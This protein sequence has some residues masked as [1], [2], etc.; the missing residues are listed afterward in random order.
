MLFL[1]CNS[2]FTIPPPEKTFWAFCV[3]IDVIARQLETPNL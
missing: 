1:R 3:H 2:F